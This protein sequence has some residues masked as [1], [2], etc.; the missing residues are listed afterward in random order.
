MLP[1]IVQLPYEMRNQKHRYREITVLAAL[2]VF[3][4]NGYAGIASTRPGIVGDYNAG[5]VSRSCITAV[6]VNLLEIEAT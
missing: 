1:Q 2:V 3:R 6:T 4:G 5:I